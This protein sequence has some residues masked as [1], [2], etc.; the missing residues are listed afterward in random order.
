MLPVMAG[1]TLLFIIHVRANA[2]RVVQSRIDYMLSPGKST[3]LDS[4]GRDLVL[5]L[6]GVDAV[7]AVRPVLGP[8][9]CIDEC[10]VQ[11]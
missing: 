1:L 3:G 5:P 9:I 2:S 4:F 8:K 6:P 11:S 10:A 7:P